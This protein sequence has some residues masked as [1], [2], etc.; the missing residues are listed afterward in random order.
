M[1]GD[2]ATD[3]RRINL[4]KELNGYADY[5]GGI[6][7]CNGKNGVVTWDKSGT[8]TLGASCTAT[9]TWAAWPVITMKRR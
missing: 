9:T 3:T 8:P 5:V 1:S 2:N 4:L 7:G 6:A